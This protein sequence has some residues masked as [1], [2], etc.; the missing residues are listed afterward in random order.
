MNLF[1]RKETTYIDTYFK[2]FEK[3]TRIYSARIWYHHFTYINRKM[4]LNIRQQNILQ[5]HEKYQ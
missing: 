5:T 1:K 4:M 3:I 2:K